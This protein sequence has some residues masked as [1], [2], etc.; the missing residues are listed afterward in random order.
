MPFVYGQGEKKSGGGRGGGGGSASSPSGGSGPTC[1]L[2]QLVAAISGRK[3]GAGVGDGA[4]GTGAGYDADAPVRP[5]RAR[6]SALNNTVKEG[7]MP[8]VVAIA[9]FSP[10]AE[11]VPSPAAGGGGGEERGDEVEKGA[12]V[13]IAEDGAVRGRGKWGVMGGYHLRWEFETM[14]LDLGGDKIVRAAGEGEEG[15]RDLYEFFLDQN[16]LILA[17]KDAPKKEDAIV[18]VR[19]EVPR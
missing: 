4:G 7:E 16:L 11:A 10:A 19:D 6:I 1:T 3:D 12:K 14:N 17:W 8:T 9:G 5:L 2:G 13:A 18:F 15:I